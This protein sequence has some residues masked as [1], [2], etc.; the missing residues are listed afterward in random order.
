MI[1]LKNKSEIDRKIIKTLQD[2]YLYAGIKQGKDRYL[3]GKELAAKLGVSR[4]AVWKRIKRLKERY[5]YPIESRPSQGYRLSQGHL[6]FND[7]SLSLDLES[8]LIGRPLYFYHTVESTNDIA[9]KMAKD[10][11]PEGT[12]IIA[13]LQEKGRGRMG[14]RWQ[15]PPGVN[16]YTSL[17]LR[18]PISPLKAPQITFVSA[19]A[20]AETI[21]GFCPGLSPKIKW[22]NDILINYKKVSGILT[23]MNSEMD[24]VDFIISGIGVNVNMT[25]D[26]FLED[27]RGIA[28]SIKIETGITIDRVAFL[29]RLFIEFE[30]QYIRYLNEG[31]TP[32]LESWRSFSCLDGKE[33]EVIQFEERLKGVVQ[34]VDDEGALLLKDLTGRISRVISGDVIVVK[35]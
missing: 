6:P 23:E 9:Y 17:I 21:K 2:K 4:T 3:S 29:K 30:R 20:V 15:S 22:P 12:A 24:R 19:I 1:E 25:E 35:D 28:T 26:M 8:S 33:V 13:D 34:G 11:Y 16:I 5:G 7:L 10:G 18:P 32:I 31:F 27:L 14:R